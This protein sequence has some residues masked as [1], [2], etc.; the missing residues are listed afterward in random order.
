MGAMYLNLIFGIYQGWFKPW[1]VRIYNRVELFNEVLVAFV[2][3]QTVI[4]T[5]FVLDAE[6]KPHFGWLMISTI[7]IMCGVNFALTLRDAF[8]VSKP[9]L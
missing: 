9:R 3:Y 5:D 2:T 6:V 8:R 1:S 4:F 7:T